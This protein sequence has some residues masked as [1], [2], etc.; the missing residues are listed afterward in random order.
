MTLV[1][2]SSEHARDL[3]ER[4]EN[5]RYLEGVSIPETIRVTADPIDATRWADIVLIV[6]PSQRVREVCAVFSGHLGL[7]YWI[8]K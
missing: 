5:V 8:W 4:R 3:D 7:L 2:H 6:V 1:T